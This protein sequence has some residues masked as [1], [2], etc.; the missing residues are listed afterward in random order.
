MESWN[1]EVEGAQ[2]E[3]FDSLVIRNKIFFEHQKQ[4]MITPHPK[5]TQNKT[6]KQ[7]HAHTVW[8][9]GSNLLFAPNIRLQER[10]NHTH[11]L[12]VSKGI[13][14]RGFDISP[15]QKKQVTN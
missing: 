13:I 5:K 11:C 2:R 1:P 3:M 15:P 12:R 9:V 6:K 14:F 8:P 4:L 7:Y 10:E